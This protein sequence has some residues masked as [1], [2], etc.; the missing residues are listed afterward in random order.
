MQTDDIYQ[1]AIDWIWAAVAGAFIAV[2][3]AIVRIWRHEERIK[4]LEAANTERSGALRDLT[5]KVDDN[6]ADIGNRIDELGQDIRADLRVI[7]GR[8][9]DKG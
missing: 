2:S 5:R 9:M 8:V 6:H 7:L 4:A 1:H 3:G